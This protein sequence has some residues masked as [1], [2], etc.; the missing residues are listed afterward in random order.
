VVE[1]LRRAGT[2]GALV[3]VLGALDADEAEALARLRSG[4]T[5]C[6]AVLVDTDSWLPGS[7][8]TRAKATARHEQTAVLLRSAGWRVLPVVHGTLLASVWPLAAGRGGV[9]RAPAPTS[10]RVTAGARR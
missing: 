4:G 1:R 3:A 8:A 2:G 6:I 7:A 5:A 9:V 10:T